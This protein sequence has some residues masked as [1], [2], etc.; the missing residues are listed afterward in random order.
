MPTVY[1]GGRTLI[2][3]ESDVK[4]DRMTGLLRTT[5]GVS[6][7]SDADEV[8]RFGGAYRVKRLPDGLCLLQRGRRRSHYEIVPASPMPLPEYQRLLDEIELEQPIEE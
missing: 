4:L 6:V 1:R 7:D 3:K 5:H 2:A 8:A